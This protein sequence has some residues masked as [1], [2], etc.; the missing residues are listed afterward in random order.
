[1]P[2][3][4]N[5]LSHLDRV[6]LKVLAGPRQK[7]DLVDELRPLPEGLVQLQDKRVSPPVLDREEGSEMGEV[8]AHPLGP[9]HLWQ[10]H[11]L[12]RQHELKARRRRGAVRLHHRHRLR[13]GNLLRIQFVGEPLKLNVEF[14]F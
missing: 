6:E 2:L 3:L 10:L 13:P 7:L 8:G 5:R 11:I 4:F 14:L 12:R 1:V 9:L